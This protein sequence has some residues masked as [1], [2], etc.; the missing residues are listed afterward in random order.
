MSAIDFVHQSIEAASNFKDLHAMTCTRCLKP[1]TDLSNGQAA[2]VARL[3]LPE[4]ETARL[5]GLGLR[6]GVL[7]KVLQC[8][9]NEPVLLAVG[10]CRIGVN[11]ALAK[12]IYVF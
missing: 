10:D 11:Y 2:T 4:G 9:V 7:V 12:K 1:V 3:K 8:C 6:C 5:S